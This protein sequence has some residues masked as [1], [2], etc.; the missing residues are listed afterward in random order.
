MKKKFVL[1]SLLFAALALFL[2]P[3]DS[4]F[5]SEH[6]SLDRETETAVSVQNTNG[7]QYVVINR[8]TTSFPPHQIWF[9]NGTKRGWLTRGYYEY[10]AGAWYATYSGYIYYNA[11]ISPYTK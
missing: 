4:V 9:D 8:T 3:K 11:P 7:K 6:N 10:A 1:I 5:A 2:F